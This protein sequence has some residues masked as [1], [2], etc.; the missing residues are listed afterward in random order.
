MPMNA[1]TPNATVSAEP[2]EREGKPANNAE[3]L[4]DG[5]HDPTSGGVAAGLVPA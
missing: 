3:E 4:F 2:G 5:C 1:K